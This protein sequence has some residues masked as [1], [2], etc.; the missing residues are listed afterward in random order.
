MSDTK[1]REHG[2]N[3]EKSYVGQTETQG[4]TKNWMRVGTVLV[5]RT[6]GVSPT[7]QGEGR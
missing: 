2:Q 5:A 3:Y 7:S 1:G 4:V 6:A